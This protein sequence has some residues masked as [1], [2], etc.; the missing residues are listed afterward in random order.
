[1]FLKFCFHI[2]VMGFISY[3]S[4]IS[5]AAICGR[6]TSIRGAIEVLRLTNENSGTTDRM[7]IIAS[8]QMPL[9][10]SD[11]LV[12]R[13]AARAK[14][15][16][17]N[18]TTLTLGPHSRVEIQNHFNPDKS[19]NHLKLTYGKLRALFKEDKSQK[20]QRLPEK[21]NE[22]NMSR[23]IIKTPA[24]VAG[25]R[26]TDFYVAYSPQRKIA[27]QAT[28]TGNVIVENDVTGEKIWVHPGKQVAVNA[29]EPDVVE[30]IK[31]EIKAGKNIEQIKN[32]VGISSLQAEPI[33][34]E[35][36]EEIRQTSAIARNDKEFTSPEAVKVLGEPE[37]WE[38][39]KDEIP[40]DLKEI[41]EEF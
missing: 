2:F 1:M 10:C 4:V 17:V 8:K 36:K 28:L 20:P 7:G 40:I 14:V 5:N 33:K 41:K 21:N 27:E 18:K 30:K 24:M 29:L 23:L 38:L 25:V 15:L 34:E 35:V 16:L 11:I 19:V 32:E 39:P 31:N 37:K 6:I 3:I 12:T 9:W 13:K 22:K 26:G